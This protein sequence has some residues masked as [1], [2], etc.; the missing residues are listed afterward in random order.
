MQCVKN[1]LHSDGPSFWHSPG[2]GSGYSNLSIRPIFKMGGHKYK[3]IYFDARGRAETIRLILAA[4]G[5]KYEDCRVPFE[6]WS[7]L[8]SRE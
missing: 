5:I 6:E 3:L 8:K 1:T 2:A 7:S 4:A